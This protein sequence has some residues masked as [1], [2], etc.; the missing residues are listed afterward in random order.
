MFENLDMKQIKGIRFEDLLNAV[1]HDYTTFQKLIF[2]EKE[3]G[4]LI[5]S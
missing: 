5:S 4:M 1:V 2:L 3:P